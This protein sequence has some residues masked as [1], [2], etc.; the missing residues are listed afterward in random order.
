MSIYKFIYKPHSK[1]IERNYSVKTIV[2]MN[3]N[4]DKIHLN[5]LEIITLA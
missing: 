3:S 5:N 1:G 2:I 4:H